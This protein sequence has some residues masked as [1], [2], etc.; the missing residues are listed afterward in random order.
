M[1]A[2]SLH[3]ELTRARKALANNTVTLTFS[4]GP[5]PLGPRDVNTKRVQSVHFQLMFT[6]LI[7]GFLVFSWRVMDLCVRRP[8]KVVVKVK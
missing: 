5:R 2:K 4:L 7:V 1:E 8:K 3:Q 6:F